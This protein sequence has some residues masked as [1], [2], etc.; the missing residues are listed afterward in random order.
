MPRDAHVHAPGRGKTSS[1]TDGWGESGSGT[2]SEPPGEPPGWIIASSAQRTSANPPGGSAAR[3]PT[4]C[5]EGS[6][7]ARNVSGSPTSTGATRVPTVNV[8]VVVGPARQADGSFLA[9]TDTRTV[10][11]PSPSN[12]IAPPASTISPGVPARPTQYGGVAIG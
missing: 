12:C 3:T 10:Y 4:N 6:G 8:E 5:D 1:L 11:V 9:P 7:A 2:T